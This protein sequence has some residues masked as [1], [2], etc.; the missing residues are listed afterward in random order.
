MKPIPR[1]LA[2]IREMTIE[3]MRDFKEHT[4]QEVI[5]IIEQTCEINLVNV[6]KN[7]VGY[8]LRSYPGITK[9]SRGY[10]QVAFKLSRAQQC[11]IELKTRC[12]VNLTEV[13]HETFCDE[14]FFNFPQQN[15]NNELKNLQ[16]QLENIKLS[17]EIQD[18]YKEVF[19]VKRDIIKARRSLS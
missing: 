12:Q 19:K 2:Q 3:V 9:I 15:V 13:R 4:K 5:E 17:Q 1:T 10:R 7:R 18:T 11:N 14:F 8:V 6:E 16:I